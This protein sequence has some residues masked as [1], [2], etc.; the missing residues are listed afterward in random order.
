[1]TFIVDHFT[2]GIRGPIAHLRDYRYPNKWCPF[3]IWSI[4]STVTR[5]SMNRWQSLGL[6]KTCS[7]RAG[8]AAEPEAGAA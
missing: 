1:M 4:P 5:L 8:A 6:L 2:R 3:Q 7:Q